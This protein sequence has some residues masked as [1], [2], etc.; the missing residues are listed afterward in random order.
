MQRIGRL[1]LSFACGAWA[2]AATV[3]GAAAFEPRM[4]TPPSPDFMRFFD[5]LALT[6]DYGPF[7]NRPPWVRKWNGPVRIVLDESAEPLRLEIEK[8]ANRFTEWTELPFIVTAPGTETPRDPKNL[9]TVK[10]LPRV[11]FSRLYKTRDVVCQTET[12]GVGGTLQIGYMVVSEGYSDC[13]RHEFMHALGFDS[14]WYPERPSAIKSVLAY[15]E[16]ASRSADYSTWD[17][18]AIR[19]LYDWRIHAGMSRQ[20]SLSIAHEVIR[21]RPQR[22]ALPASD[23]AGSAFR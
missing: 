19:L 12:H 15:R 23:S 9:I 5:T 17:I 11:T 20:K 16:S 1:L 18:T 14:H 8:I 6:A 2:L 3:S 13:L 4:S 21:E 7:N 10:L 22:A